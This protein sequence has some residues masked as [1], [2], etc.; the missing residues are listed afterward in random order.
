M[1]EM[2][3]FKEVRVIDSDG[4]QAGIFPI[5]SALSKAYEKGMDL[6]LISTESSP[7]VCKIAD[8][9]KLK[10]EQQKR[11]KQSK[12]GSKAGQLKEIKMS[13]KISEHD[14]MVKAERA[15]EFLEKGYK[16][17]VAVMFRGR[18]QTHPDVGRR[19]LE[20]MITF[21]STVGKIE[22]NISQEG[23][24]MFLLVAPAK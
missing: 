2:I 18:E 13:P 14:F 9:G 1:N 11:D 8:I 7:P 4:S 24:A 6:I 15:K 20:K 23:R 3:R 12:K 16:V 19:H 22:G 21:L 5:Q 17:K 10:Y